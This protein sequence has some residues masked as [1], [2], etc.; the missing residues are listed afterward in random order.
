MEDWVV[1]SYDGTSGCLCGRYGPAAML[2]AEDSGVRYL[3]PSGITNAV[4]IG[5]AKAYR[6]VSEN[7][8]A[9]TA[10]AREFKNRRIIRRLLDQLPADY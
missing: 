3:V 7:L 6:I 10:K 8:R 1:E 4:L 9:G 5:E 2:V